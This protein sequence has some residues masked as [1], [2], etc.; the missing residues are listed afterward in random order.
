MHGIGHELLHD[1][2]C[3]AGQQIFVMAAVTGTYLKQ[4]KINIY[5]L[6]DICKCSSETLIRGV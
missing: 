6:Y 5:F 2:S 4:K 3:L 1:F